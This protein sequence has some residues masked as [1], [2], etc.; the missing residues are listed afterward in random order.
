MSAVWTGFLGAIAALAAAALIVWPVAGS[1]W[2][3]AVFGILSKVFLRFRYP[4]LSTALYLG[5]GW[6]IVIAV[7]PLMTQLAYQLQQAPRFNQWIHSSSLERN[8]LV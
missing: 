2:A 8:S 7:R 3:L 5:M 1:G 6:L 4:R